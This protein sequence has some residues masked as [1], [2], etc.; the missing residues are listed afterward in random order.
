MSDG[1]ENAIADS[2]ARRLTWVTGGVLFL[3]SVVIWF[4]ARGELAGFAIAK[5]AVFASAAVLFVVGVGRAGS[6]TDRRPVSTVATLALAVAPFAQS[7]RWAPL[8]VVFWTPLV[9]VVG[10]TV[11][12]S[13]PSGTTASTIAGHLVLDGP[14]IGTAFLGIVALV[15]GLRVQRPRVASVSAT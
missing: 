7:W 15:L 2:R 13:A 9:F 8:W 14:A 6:V 5:D 10:I 4:T 1:A 12:S 11:S 3:L